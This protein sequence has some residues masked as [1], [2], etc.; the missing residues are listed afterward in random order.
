MN[1][2]INPRILGSGLYLWVQAILIISK[3]EVIEA[4]AEEKVKVTI[5]IVPLGLHHHKYV[6]H[7]LGFSK[8]RLRSIICIHLHSA[9]THTNNQPPVTRFV[10]EHFSSDNVQQIMAVN[11]LA[12]YCKTATKTLQ[13]L[14]QQ[15]KKDT[16]HIYTYICVYAILQITNK[17]QT[18]ASLSCW[19][20]AKSLKPL[21]AG[22][23]LHKL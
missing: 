5:H 1:S 19:Q 6:H 9:V 11:Y 18:P 21:A 2:C 17:S 4:E 22:G 14:W 16:Q 15:L 8:V 10:L 12:N 23:S 7:K 13:K 20:R 3:P